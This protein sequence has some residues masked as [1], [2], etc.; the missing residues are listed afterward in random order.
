M[1]QHTHEE[2]NVPEQPSEE[3]GGWPGPPPQPDAPVVAP[4]ALP[5]EPPVG[6]MPTEA[7]THDP[8]GESVRMRREAATSMREQHGS[9]HPRHEMWYTLAGLLETS[10]TELARVEFM[11]EGHQRLDDKIHQVAEQ[12]LAVMDIHPDPNGSL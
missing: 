2:P 4:P 3:Q 11:T 8:K 6:T 7:E 10:A 5:T 12:Y 1:T 9:E